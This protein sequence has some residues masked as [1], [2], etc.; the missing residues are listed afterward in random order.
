MSSKRNNSK[1]T[2]KPEL[3]SSGEVEEEYQVEKILDVRINPKT[4]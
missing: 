1:K 4:K 3:D 2:R